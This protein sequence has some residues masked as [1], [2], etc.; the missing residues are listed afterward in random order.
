MY[1]YEMADRHLGELDLRVHVDEKLAMPRQ[2]VLEMFD[3][4]G[5]SQK[6]SLT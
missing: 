6:P 1:Y 5:T 4:Q 3:Q 2:N